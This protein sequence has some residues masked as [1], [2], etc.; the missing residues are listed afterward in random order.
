MIELAPEGL[1]IPDNHYTFLLGR[2]HER[3]SLYIMRYERIP[4]AAIEE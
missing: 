3:Q 2:C 4:R 1:Q